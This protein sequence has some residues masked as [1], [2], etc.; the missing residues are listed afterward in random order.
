MNSVALWLLI[1]SA[2]GYR[3]AAVI[4]QFLTKEECMAAKA[5]INGLE[6]GKDNISL[7]YAICIPVNAARSV[8]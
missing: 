8:K 4:E 3:P 6:Q 7:Q 2:G 5:A 1:F